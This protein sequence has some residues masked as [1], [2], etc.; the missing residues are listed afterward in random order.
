MEG[1]R[2]PFFRGC[3]RPPTFLGVPLGVFLSFA[4]AFLIPAMWAF[5]F[6]L[7]LLCGL[8]TAVWLTGHLYMREV[9]RKDDQR[10]LQWILRLRVRLTQRPL[11][12]LWGTASYGPLSFQRSSHDNP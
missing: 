7:L 8:F 4:A 12:R 2:D 11:L 6:R 1:F 5:A 9:T 3:T 10:V